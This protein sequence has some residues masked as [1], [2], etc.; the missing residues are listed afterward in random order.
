MG[1]PHTSVPQFDRTMLRLCS[2]VQLGPLALR[3]N[4]PA[5]SARRRAARPHWLSSTVPEPRHKSCADHP[6]RACKRERRVVVASGAWE[7]A[8]SRR[9]QGRVGENGKSRIPGNRLRSNRWVGRVKK[10]GRGGRVRKPPR[11]NA[12]RKRH[13]PAPIA[14]R[15]SGPSTSIQNKRRAMR[16]F[17]L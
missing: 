13:G 5:N 4:G 16:S 10:F 6:I 3:V 8:A 14:R 17:S 7:K 11:S 1:W 12:T 15:N 9:G 2:A